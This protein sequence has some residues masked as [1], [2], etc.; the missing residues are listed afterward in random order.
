MAKWTYEVD[1]VTKD[2]HRYNALNNENLLPWM[3]K[4]FD[5]R[6]TFIRI[7]GGEPSMY[8]GINELLIELDND[9]YPVITETNGS[10]PITK[11][12][13]GRILA[14]WHKDKPMPMCYDAI[15]IMQ[16]PDDNWKGKLV[17]CERLKIKTMVVPYYEYSKNQIPTVKEKTYGIFDEVSVVYS[18][19]TMGQ[20]WASD[21]A[22]QEGT[23]NVL[24]DSPP[25]FKKLIKGKCESCGNV[26]S[27]EY[28]LAELWPEL[29]GGNYAGNK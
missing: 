2:G 16:N 18:S 10:L 4:Y 23:W 13:K 7:S 26:W 6:T 3:R 11:T 28:C 8:E 9:G 1:A 21:C 29:L 24:L 22:G 15:L 19:G 27:Y 5:P 20:C 17:T 12:K 25:K 14:A